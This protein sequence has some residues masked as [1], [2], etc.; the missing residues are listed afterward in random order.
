MD[1]S[2]F[3]DEMDVES[4]YDQNSECDDEDLDIKMI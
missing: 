2:N 4:D 1:K 3:E